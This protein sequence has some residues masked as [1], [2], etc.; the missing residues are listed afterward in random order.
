MTSPKDTEEE[1]RHALRAAL[2]GDATS[3]WETHP[4]DGVVA[5]Y[6]SAELGEDEQDRFEAH[7]AACARC[8]E[9]LGTV[10]AVERAAAEV[11]SWSRTD[12]SRRPATATG[13]APSR[14][15]RS[16]FGRAV[17]WMSVAAVL[18]LAITAGLV[19]GG[20]Y[21][22]G[23]FTPRAA[24]RLAAVV[25]RPVS[26]GDLSLA[27]WGGPA[28]R[29]SDLR[30]AD[31]PRFSQESLLE[32]GRADLAVE[33]SELWQG[34][35]YGSVRLDRPVLRLVRDPVG[36]WNVE[37][38]RDED[39]TVEVPGAPGSIPSAAD[40]AAR[41]AQVRLVSATVSAGTLAV[42]DR[43]AGRERDLV[44]RDVDLDYRSRVATEPAQV[45]LKG[46]IGGQ[47]VVLR[48][49]IG[50]FEGD[51]APRYRFAEISLRGV[52]VAEL[53]G[54]P[55]AVTGRL[56]FDGRLDGSGRALDAIVH[57]ATGG[58]SLELRGGAL[59]QRNL[60][61]DLVA[62]LEDFTGGSGKLAAALD[63]KADTAAVLA[64]SATDYERL[65][66]TVSVEDGGLAFSS[67]GVETDLFGATTD[68]RIAADGGVDVTGRVVLAP[69][70]SAALVAAAPAFGPI[71]ARQEQVAFPFQLRGRW[72]DVHLE[73]DVAATLAKVAFELDPRR[74]AW[75]LRPPGARG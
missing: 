3:E 4:D 37:A 24:E 45:A 47:P 13:R 2:S 54:T 28:V 67:L 29:V 38:F 27:Y 70:L 8:A 43:S 14:H 6:L 66:G 51:G 32:L 69:S 41:D 33:T 21:L 17:R 60:D 5:R 74:L 57:T 46:Q 72:P 18:L 34:R 62:A 15:R 64:R 68:G 23:R 40:A 30:I 12:E 20:S 39:G 9:D 52:D 42:T 55:A 58:G 48:G 75:A 26:I 22:L 73:V 59:E 65:G 53:P 11:A 1:W 71:V 25:G 61:R 56:T 44:I 31:D 7:V 10:A 35:L 63:G 49:E 50:P 36:E 16:S 19:A